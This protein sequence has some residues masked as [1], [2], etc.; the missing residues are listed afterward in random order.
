MSWYKQW[1]EDRK[2]KR[3]KERYREGY[4]W[5]MAAYHLEN[6]YIDNIEAM[7]YGSIK[8]PFDAGARLAVGDIRKE[9]KKNRLS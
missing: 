9:E 5:A 6:I 3:N 2:V 1:K 4:G 7:V 8:N